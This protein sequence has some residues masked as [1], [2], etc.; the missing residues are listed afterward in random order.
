M[1]KN[2]LFVDMD[3]TLAIFN[4]SIKNLDILYEEG[5]FRK[6]EPMHNV[7]HAI[8]QLATTSK[9][10]EVY[11]LSSCLDS[12]HAT[13]EKNEWIDKHL[14]EI[15]KERRVF[16][17]YGKPKHEA[18]VGG[19]TRDDILL[20]D[21]TKNLEEWKKQGGTGVKILNGINDTNK[22][23]IGPRIESQLQADLFFFKL[24]TLIHDKIIHRTMTQDYNIEERTQSAQDNFGKVTKKSKEIGEKDK[25]DVLR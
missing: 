21:Y 19:I 9:N 17:E 7:V 8:K 23:W 12:P 13:K 5:Y 18:I 10:F 22:S 25:N 6:L 11:I 14:S 20:D 15:P 24:Q 1:E 4:N 2:R 3:G 16:C